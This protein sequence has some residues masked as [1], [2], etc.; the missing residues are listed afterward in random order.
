MSDGDEAELV[1]RMRE[2]LEDERVD[3]MD[4]LD[5]AAS[6]S[7]PRLLKSPPATGR[8]AHGDEFATDYAEME[9]QQQATWAASPA[10]PQAASPPPVLLEVGSENGSSRANDAAG[11]RYAKDLAPAAAPALDRD[12]RH[13]D[14]RAIDAV[15]HATVFGTAGRFPED[16]RIGE[17]IAHKGG[18]QP[19]LG[20]VSSIAGVTGV[21]TWMSKHNPKPV[22]PSR[23]PIPEEE[24][25]PAE[26]SSRR[27]SRSLNTSRDQKT[28][29]H[30]R[31]QMDRHPAEKKVFAATFETTGRGDLFA[32]EKTARHGSV[33]QRSHHDEF[34][35]V[36]KPGR[37]GPGWSNVRWSSDA[38]NMLDGHTTGRA[39]QRDLYGQTEADKDAQRARI[40]N[41]QREHEERQSLDDTPTWQTNRHWKTSIRAVHEPD[42]PPVPAEPPTVQMSP[43]HNQQFRH[44]E[45]GQTSPFLSKPREDLF[46]HQTSSPRPGQLHESDTNEHF[47]LRGDLPDHTVNTTDNASFKAA[48]HAMN[49]VNQAGWMLNHEVRPFEGDSQVVQVAKEK[50]GNALA[51]AEGGNSARG[52]QKSLG[53]ANKV[54]GTNKGESGELTIKPHH[55]LIR[56]A[57]T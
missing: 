21:D 26:I 35:E 11:R 54:S 10:N 3:L 48:A 40:A 6:P 8:S 57:L 9:A 56:G 32:T 2:R 37:S 51:G 20:A 53:Y 28:L 23:S 19:T 22:S 13:H 1:Q 31:E 16:Q 4:D 14:D 45:S 34:H 38:S 47:P 46:H 41:A 49:Q 15:Q 39:Q 5:A 7:D 30:K 33:H 17:K 42:P 55:D 52:L 44:R 24:Q 36:H 50:W 12:H 29:T 25:Q 18:G 27:L 43:H